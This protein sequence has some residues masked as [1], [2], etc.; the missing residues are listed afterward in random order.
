MSTQSIKIQKNPTPTPTQPAVFAPK[1]AVANA[2]DTLTWHNADGQDHWPAPSVADKTGWR[3]FQ[4]PPNS[5][6]RGDVALA[7][8][9]FGVTG[10]T[11][12][13]PVVLTFNGP[14]PA[15]GAPVTLTYAKPPAPPPPAPP[16]P[17]SPWAAV[18]GPFV[19]TYV[20]PNSCSIPIDSSTF[21]LFSA[22]SGTL[23]IA[24][25]YTLNYLC[26]LHS[27][28]TGTITVNPQI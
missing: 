10:A 12:A 16:P 9:A 19:A 22:A 2:G 25:P 24:L 1:A 15:T 4:I 6:S 11:N 27:D 23:T 26:A 8:N 7:K 21:G 17:A 14:A 3:Q 18:K 13:N 5:E 20:S 28:E